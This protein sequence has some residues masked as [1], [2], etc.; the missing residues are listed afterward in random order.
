MGPA[1]AM[2]HLRSM[3]GLQE[4]QN[5][6][7]LHHTSSRK[8]GISYKERIPQNMGINENLLYKERPSSPRNNGQPYITIKTLKA[9]AK[10]GT[11]DF[12]ALAL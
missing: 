4:P 2:W 5:G 12:P 9:L 3:R 8:S 1:R 6:E 7:S 10:G 11:N